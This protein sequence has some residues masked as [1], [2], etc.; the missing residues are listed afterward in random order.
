MVE[1]IRHFGYLSL[2]KI[3]LGNHTYQRN[4]SKRKIISMCDQAW[5]SVSFVCNNCLHGFDSV[6][7]DLF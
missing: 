2:E 6:I 1:L 3:S 7:V 4:M 5:L